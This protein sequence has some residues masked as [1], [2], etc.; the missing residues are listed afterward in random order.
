MS[1]ENVDPLFK[2]LFFPELQ[3]GSELCQ[4]L[5]TH[6]NRVDDAMPDP[7]GSF[8]ARAAM[9]QELGKSAP[10][11]D[12]DEELG[13]GALE[14]NTSEVRHK[15]GVEVEKCGAQIWR[16]TY[17]G[18]TITAIE[19]EDPELPGGRMSFDAEGNEVA[20]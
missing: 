16:Y 19:L 2:L 7:V 10:G 3:D 20:A 6:V 4:S 13:G 11:A 17:A 14:K 18:G 15:D 12:W 9:A 5:Y 1:D 8:F